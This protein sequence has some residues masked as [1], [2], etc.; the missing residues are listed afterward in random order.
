MGVLDQQVA[1]HGWS[2]GVGTVGSPLPG[3]RRISRSLQMVLVLALLT[4]AA[5][6]LVRAQGWKPPDRMQVFVAVPADTPVNYGVADAALHETDLAITWIEEQVGSQLRGGDV[7][8]AEVVQLQA[9][10]ASLIGDV[11][12]AFDVITGQ[13]LAHVGQQDVFPVILADIR[14]ETTDTG[15]L[16]CGLG[17][18]GGLVMFLG[19]CPGDELS[20]TSV[21]G[22]AASH[23]IAHELVHGLGAA[24]PC[25]RSATTDGH[26]ND[27][28]SDIIFA[29]TDRP[30]RGARF[31]LDSGN[32][33]YFRHGIAGCPDI[34]DS[35]LWEV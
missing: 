16:T 23:T 3:G 31:T 15:L 21:W 11:S 30:H 32:D 26:V 19:N 13:V 8:F 29:G 33:D 2:T 5:T 20:T 24:W 14:T 34:A 6:P 22:S 9:T 1:D 12:A 27:D 35:P 28:P 7:R 18:V 4:L 25:G 10:S 17:G